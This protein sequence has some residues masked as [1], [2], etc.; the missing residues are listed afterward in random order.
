M[1]ELDTT[2]RRGTVLIG[3]QGTYVIK[4]VLAEGGIGRVFLGQRTSD[5]QE[6]AVKMLHGGRFPLTDVAKIRFRKEISLALRIIHPNIIRSYD[7][8][9]HS[10]QD[11]FVMEYVDGGT[12]AQRIQRKDYPDSLAF[13]WCAEILS[14]LNHLHENG[15]VH[16]D[17]KPNNILLTRGGSAKIADLGIVRDVSADAYLTLSGDQMGSVLYISRHQREHPDSADPSDDAYSACCCLYEILSKQR[18]HVFPEHLYEAAKGSIP[19]YVADLI[20]GCLSGFEGETTLHLL[21]ECFTI[22]SDGIG[23]LSELSMVDALNDRIELLTSKARNL[24]VVRKRFAQNAPLSNLGVVE[25]SDF[26]GGRVAYLD[27]KTIVSVHDRDD[28]SRQELLHITKLET[29]GL[30]SISTGSVMSPRKMVVVPRRMTVLAGRAGVEA[31]TLGESEEPACCHKWSESELGRNFHALD[32]AGHPTR[33]LA[34]IVAHGDNPIV[35][36]LAES[37]FFKI[38]G[39]QIPENFYYPRLDFLGDELLAVSLPQE[40]LV[41]QYNVERET[42]TISH[43]IPFLSEVLDLSG[44]RGGEVLYIAHAHGLTA[45]NILDDSRTWSL[46]ASTNVVWEVEASPNDLY[47]A[48]KFGGGALGTGRI[49]ILDR[50]GVAMAYLPDEGEND[51]LRNSSHMAWSPSGRSLAVTDFSEYL[52]VFQTS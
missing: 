37:R 14:A 50:S 11:F 2:V 33:S 42:A 18:I 47:V 29:D 27:E 35:L 38:E 21:R 4:S 6:V 19:R 12:V 39:I 7:Y 15:Y 17:L 52:T 48:G 32:L 23:K 9:L 36:D 40:I 22:A 34:A 26:R 30:H 43:S 13:G 45:H 44:S 46:P 5:R 49:A 51:T 1:S 41:C 31:Y 3:A 25:L 10:A 20:M 8:G 28:E 24:G 16:R